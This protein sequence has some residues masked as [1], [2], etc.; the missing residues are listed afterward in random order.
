M[1]WNLHIGLE[2]RTSDAYNPETKQITPNIEHQLRT[3]CWIDINTPV[4]GTT[5]MKDI[6]LSNIPWIKDDFDFG[7]TKLIRMDE[8]DFLHRHV[9]AGLTKT[10]IRRQYTMI[11]Q[12]A[13]PDEYTGG[14]FLLGDYRLP[15]DRGFCCLFDGGTQPHQVKKILSG[16]RKSWITWM[17]KES[18][19]IL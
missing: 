2:W 9:D 6:M 8:G 14:D 11:I 19:T 5:T 15:K 4:D 10:L 1:L 17:P 7:G 3:E 18:L 12:L 16:T 13:E